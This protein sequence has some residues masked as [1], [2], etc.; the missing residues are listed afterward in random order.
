MKLFQD[1]KVPN[2]LESYN[3]LIRTDKPESPT[4][5]VFVN[6]MIVLLGL[7][8][9]ASIVRATS[10]QPAYVIPH[11]NEM[12]LALGAY[13]SIKI[14]SNYQTAKGKEAILKADCTKGNVDD[15]SSDAS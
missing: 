8:I 13:K 11:F 15:K 7:W 4:D 2:F 6:G 1:L 9:Y 10:N 5:F 3:N 12:L 14:G